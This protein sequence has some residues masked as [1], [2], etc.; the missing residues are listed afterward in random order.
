MGCLG[1][2]CGLWVLVVGV[3]CGCG[4]WL[5]VV[6]VGVPVTRQQICLTSNNDYLLLFILLNF[7]RLSTLFSSRAE[8]GV[9]VFFLPY[10][11]LNRRELHV[12]VVKSLLI[13]DHF[14]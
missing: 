11:P 7:K 8:M 6:G 10:I 5:W 4:L 3:G 1:F 9:T 2:G 14:E 12:C 13:Y